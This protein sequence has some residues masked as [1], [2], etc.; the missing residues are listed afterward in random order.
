M[1]DSLIGQLSDQGISVC[2]YEHISQRNT[3]LKEAAYLTICDAWLHQM[4]LKHPTVG[5]WVR[6]AVQLGLS[7]KYPVSAEA[8]KDAP[9]VLQKAAHA[10]HEFICKHGLS[11]VF[12]VAHSAGAITASMLA[13]MPKTPHAHAIQ[14]VVCFGYPFKFPDRDEEPYRTAHLAHVATP[15]LIVQGDEDRYGSAE[16]AHR[17]TLASSIQVVSVQSGHDYDYACKQTLDQIRT[18]LD[19][20]AR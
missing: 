10:L 20:P 19:L 8:N 17:Y 3:R 4:V 13:S 11:Q 6:R 12:L 5:P 14:K 1:I 16:A 7:L 2:W 18:F 15:F 9:V